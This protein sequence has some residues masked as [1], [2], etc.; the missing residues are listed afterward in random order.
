MNIITWA[1]IL[2]KTG[3]QDFL[4]SSTH[5]LHRKIYEEIMDLMIFHSHQTKAMCDLICDRGERWRSIDPTD[6]VSLPV[7]DE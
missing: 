4:A 1:K 2:P 7:P 6:S 3:F 5:N